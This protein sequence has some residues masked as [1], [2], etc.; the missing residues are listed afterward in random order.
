MIDSVD[1][2]LQVSFQPPN[3]RVQ[4]RWFKVHSENL[5][6]IGCYSVG[7]AGRFYERLKK[8]YLTTNG[9]GTQ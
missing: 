6:P 9:N 2:A 8:Y 1:E 7:F 5:A 3:E 4:C